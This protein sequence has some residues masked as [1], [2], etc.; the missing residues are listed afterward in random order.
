MKNAYISY[1]GLLDNFLKLL[2]RTNPILSSGLVALWL[3][4]IGK[5]NIKFSS[6]KQ[7]LS[8]KSQVKSFSHYR[9]EN[10]V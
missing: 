8:I 10:I 9:I 2:T 5:F 4:K 6:F 3:V 7:L 1:G